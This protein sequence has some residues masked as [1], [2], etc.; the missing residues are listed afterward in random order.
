MELA[1][2]LVQL[3]QGSLN[4]RP[5]EAV[6]GRLILELFRP[7]QGG[8]GPGHAVHGLGGGALVLFLALDGVPADQHRFCVLF[9]GGAAEYVGV[10][11][12]QLLHH[13]VHHVLHG[14]PSPLAL[15][16]RVEHHLHQHVAQLLLE[17]N[18][19][20]VV[21]GLGGFIRLLQEAAA[22]GLMCLRLVP[23]AAIFRAEE[24]DDLQ[25]VRIVIVRFPCKIYHTYA[26]IARGFRGDAPKSSV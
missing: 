24:P 6:G 26:P 23:G 8:Q 13:A 9:R 10:A 1:H 14:E 11:E 12:Q 20:V 5:V 15:N 7:P 18:G 25:Q 19:I 17:E 3:G 2:L 22:D 4:I 16:V 21:D